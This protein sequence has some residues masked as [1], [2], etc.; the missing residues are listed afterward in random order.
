MLIRT[1]RT[2]FSHTLSRIHAFS[3]KIMDL[4][5]S[6]SKWWQFCQGLNALRSV[7]LTKWSW[8]QAMPITVASHILATA[9]CNVISKKHPLFLVCIPGLSPRGSSQSAEPMLPT[10]YIF[11]S[12]KTISFLLA[13]NLMVVVEQ[14]WV[15]FSDGILVPKVYSLSHTYSH[16]IHMRTDQLISVY[17]WNRS[18]ATVIDVCETTYKFPLDKTPIWGSNI[19]KQKTFVYDD[20]QMTR[21]FYSVAL[22][23]TSSCVFLK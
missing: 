7:R 18:C 23:W 13:T 15:E 5:V 11:V 12:I 6:S 3:F 1:L 9:A 16:I 22:D 19:F 21:K 2:D 20:V 4:K 17:I 14:R 10:D 8:S